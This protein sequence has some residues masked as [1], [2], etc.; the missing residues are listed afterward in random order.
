MYWSL[1]VAKLTKR[2]QE[3]L[4]ALRKRGDWMSRQEIAEG[5]GRDRL[6]PHDFSLL[7]RLALDGLIERREAEVEESPRGFRFEYRVKEDS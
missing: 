2:Q 3:M 4:E 5:T 6:T 7:D 1:P